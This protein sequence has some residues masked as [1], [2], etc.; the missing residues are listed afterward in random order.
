MSGG[1]IRTCLIDVHNDRRYRH[2]SGK[3][4]RKRHSHEY[5]CHAYP[6]T[7][8]SKRHHAE[9]LRLRSLTANEAVT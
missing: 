5:F 7:S 2:A 3:S 9:A 6:R 1:I 8:L 4:E